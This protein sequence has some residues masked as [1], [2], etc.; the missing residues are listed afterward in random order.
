MPL[1]FLKMARALSNRTV[2]ISK[3]NTTLDTLKGA[4]SHKNFND[5]LI[6]ELEPQVI[7]KPALSSFRKNEENELKISVIIPVLQEEKLLEKNISY[8]TKELKS[9]FNIEL[10]ISDGGSTDRT[11]EIAL[12]Y[13][14]KLALHKEI[15]KQ[16]IAEGR[17]KGSELAEGDIFIF[18][19]GDTRP[20]NPEKFF[21][22]I[23]NWFLQNPDSPALTCWVK[24]P[25]ED[26]IFKD[27]IFYAIHNHYVNLL[28]KIGLG[29][30][31]GECQVVRRDIFNKIGGYNSEI[32]AGEDFDLFRRI[33]KLGKIHFAK[34]IKVLESPRRFRKY[35]YFKIIMQ[36]L[37]NSLSVMLFNKSVSNN[38]EAVR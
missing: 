4:I 8:F 17:N 6:S 19:N 35:G 22:Y 25:K 26:E 16:T 7:E 38:W 14:D 1:F 2:E 12:K 28:N 24:V 27:R 31:R 13:C 30:G 20:E 32:A 34:K 10:I 3:G 15:R 29:M 33:S 36:W 9:K 18:I 21:S 11:I 5:D 37:L 23:R